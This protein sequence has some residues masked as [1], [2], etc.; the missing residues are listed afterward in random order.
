MRLHHDELRPIQM[1]LHGMKLLGADEG[2]VFDGLSRVFEID[3]QAIP[4]GV[5]ALETLHANPPPYLVWTPRHSAAE[6]MAV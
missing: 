6:T 1:N 5:N 3:P 4:L 2:D